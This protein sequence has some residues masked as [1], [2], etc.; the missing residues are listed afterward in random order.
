MNYLADTHI[1]IWYIEGNK[2]LSKKIIS[3]LENSQNK[4]F[5]SNAALW[6]IAIKASIGKL[7]LSISLTKFESFLSENNFELLEYDYADMEKLILLPLHHS[8]P[9]DR[10][11]IAQAIVK[12][13]S[14]ISDDEKFRQYPIKLVL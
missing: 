3:I 9:F 5:I 13:L 4:I 11:M 2:K 6:E 8:D 10:M 7:S 1:L 14:V 12:N